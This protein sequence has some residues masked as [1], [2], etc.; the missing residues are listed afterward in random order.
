MIPIFQDNDIV[1]E[2]DNSSVRI[3]NFFTR[4]KSLKIFVAD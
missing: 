2:S 4:N 1:S 3:S